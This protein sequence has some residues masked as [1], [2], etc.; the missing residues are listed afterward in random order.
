L[1]RS[2]RDV[3]DDTRVF[4]GVDVTFN[5]RMQNSFTFSGGTSTGKVV[6]DWC[7]I[8]D[9]VPESYLLKR[10]PDGSRRTPI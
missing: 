9:A 3:G 5:V 1:I 7:E 8:R 6:N 10:P 2:T 4:N